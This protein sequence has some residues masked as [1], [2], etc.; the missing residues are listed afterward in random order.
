MNRPRHIL[1]VTNGLHGGGAERLLTNIVLPMRERG[2]TRVSVVS[3]TAGGVFRRPLEDAGVEVVDLGLISVRDA[4][5]GVF[6]LA[7]VLR[8][9]RPDVVYA[10][11]YHANLMAMFALWLAGLRKT[12]LFWGVFCTE[13]YGRLRFRLVVRANA[14][15]SRYVNGVIYNAAE[16]R[17]YHRAMGFRESRSIIISNCVDP[18]AFRRDENQRASFRDALGIGPET[19]V[20]VVVA[21][22]DPMKDW[23]T[24]LAA[25]RDLPGVVTVAAGLGTEDLAPQPG[26]IGL[27]WRDD[28]ARVLSGADI[29]LLGSAYGEGASLALGEAMACGL[30]SIVTGVGASASQAGPAAIVVE[31]RDPAAIREAILAL[32][33]D[34]ELRRRMARAAE[35]RA[36]HAE[37]RRDTLRVMRSLVEATEVCE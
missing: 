2:D 21:R 27:G 20:V 22:I 31:P 10:W 26:F 3:L 23:P 18:D 32:A 15:L 24:V 12:R 35:L 37:P 28:I 34:P 29:F 8:E 7:S 19:V 5:R 30:P 36:S 16:A 33:R 4:V 11:M 13:S 1:Y 9:R 25:V 6:A 17:D 14:F